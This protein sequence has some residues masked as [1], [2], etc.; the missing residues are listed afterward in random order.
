MRFKRFRKIMALLL[1]MVCSIT[2]FSGC[3]FGNTEVVWTSYLGGSTVCKVG[4]E[5]CSLSD[6]KVFLLNYRNIYGKTF[7]EK[8]WRKEQKGQTMEEYMKDST[9]SQLAKMKT[10]VLLAGEQNV[11]LSGK[12]QEAVKKAARIYYD[13]L[14]REDI[15][16]LGVS[17]GSIRDLYSDMALATKLFTKLTGGV[18]EEV[19]DDDARVMQVE[20]IVLH[21]KETA[22]LV[23]KKLK[24]GSEFASLASY[25]NMASTTKT[26]LYKQKISE[27]ISEELA[28]LGDGEVSDCIE[29]AGKFY[30]FKVIKKIDRELTEQNKEV[31]VKE[32]ASEA[33]D[34]VYDAFSNK[35][36]SSY[37][38][39][40]WESFSIDDDVEAKTDSFFEVFHKELDFMKQ[41]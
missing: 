4:D 14:E 12:E 8:T 38:R 22:R 17:E 20:Q 3:G 26:T 30:Y 37:N 6:A 28:R 15:S 35:I 33:F 41:E 32:R 24:S 10:M 23:G 21:D 9:L 1:V 5:S 16:Y 36:S 25:Y 29:E 40:A 27:T 11:K 31:I 2:S 18:D 19:S 7:G 39:S 34:N 13:S